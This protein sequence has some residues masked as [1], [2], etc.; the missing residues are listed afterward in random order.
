MTRERDK[1]EQAAQQYLNTF[2]VATFQ[3]L[4]LYW[5]ERNMRQLPW[6]KD[7][8]PYKIWVSE[9]MLQQTQVDTVIPYYE[10]F[11]SRFPTLEALAEAEEEEVL[12]Y[13]EGL[14]YYSRA[15]NLHQA[16]KEVKER[17]GG[18]VPDNRKEIASLKGVG[19]Y[20]AGAILSI[21]YG[22]PEPAVDGN[23]LRVIS[24]LLHIEED[25]QKAK[26]RHL[27]EE[28]VRH[29]IPKGRASYFNQ[30]LMELG[31]LVCTPKS[32]HCLTC[33]VQEVCRA[34]QAGMQDQLPVKGKKKK[35]KTVKI[36]AGVLM[37]KGHV[38][39]RQRPDNGLLAKLYEFPNVQWDDQE[40]DETISR[41][42]FDMYGLRTATVEQW[43][44][45]QHTFT[46][47]IWEISVYRLHLAEPLDKLNGFV[48]PQEEQP[49]SAARWERIEDL[50][51]YPFPV[52]HQKIKKEIWKRL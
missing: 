33:P 37:E 13:W 52:S 45:V 14:G 42:L 9:V 44:S 23:V 38:L 17:Y 5:F 18:R 48:F 7:Q 30:G 49:F 1:L 43:P 34:Y 51:R 11:M 36:V 2:P 35:P 8:E 32:P 47:L 3:K 21:A 50:E 28:I 20:T 46:H 25:I 41:Y 4:L 26:T 19:P 27:F 6:R 15:R 24:R 29:L 22:Q 31:A 39:I 12:K 10:R 40:P 16:V